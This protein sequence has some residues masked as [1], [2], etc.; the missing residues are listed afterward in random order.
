MSQLA[1]QVLPTSLA[2]VVSAV[3]FITILSV[4][5]VGVSATNTLPVVPTPTLVDGTATDTAVR[6][7]FGDQWLSIC[8]QSC[9]E[10]V[11]PSAEA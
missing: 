2:E 10:L 3:G 4:A 8:Y 6:G 1:L 11:L 5:P 9:L 7:L